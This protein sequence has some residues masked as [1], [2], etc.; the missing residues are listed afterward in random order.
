M[1]HVRSQVDPVPKQILTEHCNVMLPVDIMFINKQAFFITF[2]RTIHFG[3]IHAPSN[4][5]VNTIITTLKGVLQVFQ[6][7]GFSITSRHADSEFEPIH[8]YYPQLQTAD[9]D[10]HVPEIERYIRSVKDRVR[11]SYRML[12]FSHVPQIILI[13]LVRNAVL[14]M[15]V[16]PSTQDGLGDYLPWYIMM[17][18]P[19]TYKA[20]MQCEF[21]Q[22][23]QTH[24]EHDNSMDEQMT[25]VICLGTTGNQ[26]GVPLLYVPID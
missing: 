6:H 18:C 5:Q 17:G 9:T 2:S 4:R 21:G 24:E 23:A 1:K 10:G 16:F 8:E 20:H 7:R 25:G 3:T 15:N 12:P 13:H 26:S 11:S 19:I 14:W 22:Y